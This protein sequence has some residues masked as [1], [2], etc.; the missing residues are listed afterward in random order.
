ML[1]DRHTT[2][3]RRLLHMSAVAAAVSMAGCIV[4]YAGREISIELDEADGTL[5]PTFGY[6]GTATPDQIARATT[7]RPELMRLGAD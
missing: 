6:G 4:E 7:L 3:R 1:D 2:S 5:N